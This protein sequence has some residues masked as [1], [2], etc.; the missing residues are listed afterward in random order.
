MAT[1]K[2]R[3]AYITEQ[4]EPLTATTRP[5]FGEYG[6]YIDGKITALICDS[7]VFLKPTDATKHLSEAPPYPGAK[8]YR[9]VPDEV[10]DDADA[11]KSLVAASATLLPP[12]KPRTSTTGRGA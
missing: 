7:T 2:D 9:L 1:P 12:P 10:I 8:P 3:V 5:M 11:F 4:L 6:L